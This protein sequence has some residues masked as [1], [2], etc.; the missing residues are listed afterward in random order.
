MG[1]KGDGGMHQVCCLGERDL[2]GKGVFE[3]KFWDGSCDYGMGI[4]LKEG[5]KY[6]R[7]RTHHVV[8]DI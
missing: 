5:Q 8:N 1:R 3:K 6:C 7:V 4:S 2:D